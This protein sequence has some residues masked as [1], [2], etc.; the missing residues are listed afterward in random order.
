[1]HL[2]FKHLDIHLS[3]WKPTWNQLETFNLNFQLEGDMGLFPI[4]T[5]FMGGA[6]GCC[7]WFFIYPQDL[8]KTNIQKVKFRGNFLLENR[9]IILLFHERHYSFRCGYKHGLRFQLES[10][11]TW[12]FKLKISSWKSSFEDERWWCTF[13]GDR[14]LWGNPRI[15]TCLRFLF[16]CDLIA[17]HIYL[18]NPKSTSTSSPHRRSLP[19][20]FGFH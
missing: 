18:S 20:A 12:I 9:R 3:T 5:F 17:Q 13:G 8:V 15:C 6:A 2:I 1:M 16:R 10:S 7:C 4:K 19:H 11:S 14:N